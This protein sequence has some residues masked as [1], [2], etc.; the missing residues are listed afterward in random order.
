MT[1]SH[2]TAFAGRPVADFDPEQR[3]A[4]PQGTAYRVR[5]EP[6]E[7]D[8]TL[9]ELLDAFVANPKAGEVTSLL[10]GSWEECYET[11]SAEIVAALVERAPQL[12]ALRHLFFG[13]IEMEEAEISWIQQSDVSPLLKAFPALETFGVRG[14]NGL[15]F[16]EP[17]LHEALR[18]LTVESGGLGRATLDQVQALQLP[19]L[20]QLHLWLGDDNYGWDGSVDDLAPVLSGKL[21]P[22]LRT[23]GLMNSCVQDAVAQAVASSPVLGQLAVLDLS[24]GTLTDAGAAALLAS[25]DVRKLERLNLRHNYLSSAMIPRLGELG[26]DVDTSDNEASEDEDYRYVEVGE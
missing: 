16:A 2:Y 12:T 18:S 6:Y 25:P 15:E 13:D 22:K 23:L 5:T 1:V 11:G 24:M 9:T 8:R 26:I 3:I 4:D 17:V 10:I 19:N 14:G 21:F 7:P 20:E